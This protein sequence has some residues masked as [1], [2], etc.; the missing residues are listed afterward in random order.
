MQTD[1]Q[2]GPSG[3]SQPRLDQAYETAGNPTDK[4]PIEQCKAQENAR[5]EG[6]VAHRNPNE[7]EDYSKATPTAMAQGIR[8]AGPGEET[9]GYTQQSLDRSQELDA[10]QMGAPG[11]GKVADAVDNP[12][13]ASGGER[14]LETDLDRKK[15]EQAPARQKVQEEKQEGFDVGGVLGQR[16]GPANPVD[17]GNVR[18]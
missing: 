8:G 5:A 1:N 12:M 13:G 6:A 3:P 10:A 9:K 15:A 14:G 7:T 11:E 4:E 17:K 2:H 16:G 18:T